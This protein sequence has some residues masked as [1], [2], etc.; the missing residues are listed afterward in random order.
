MSLVEEPVEGPASPSHDEIEV[1][2]ERRGNPDQAGQRDRRGPAAFDVRNR[3]LGD[4]CP[5]GKVLLAPAES[6]S[7][8]PNRPTYAYGIHR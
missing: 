7:Q 8:H 4:A 5:L 6:M 2:V 1:S 3:L